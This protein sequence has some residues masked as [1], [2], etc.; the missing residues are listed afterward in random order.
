ME[1]SMEPSFEWDPFK[2]AQNID[3]HGLSFEDAQRAFFDPLAVIAEDAE[4][5]A[6]E[7][8]WFCFGKVGEG[9]ATVRFTWRRGA[10]RIIGAGFWREGRRIYEEANTLYG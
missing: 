10:I 7:K 4:H 3:K 8:R 5:S 6:H 2:E 9:I 1:V